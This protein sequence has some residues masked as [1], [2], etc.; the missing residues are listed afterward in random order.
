[1]QNSK[2]I[3]TTEEFNK[4]LSFLYSYEMTM[5]DSVD[6]YTPQ[7]NLTRA[8]A[9]KLFSNFAMHVLCRTP[10]SNITIDYSDIDKV[11]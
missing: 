3:L 8:E 5:F 7:R 9:A 4:A 1:V 6:A 2:S 11:G 10:D